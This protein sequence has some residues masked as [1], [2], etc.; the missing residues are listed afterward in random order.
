MERD[1]TKFALRALILLVV[2]LFALVIYSFVL[3]PVF[4]G[5]AISSQ[6]Q[7]MQYVVYTLLTQSAPPN[8]VPTEFNMG[9]LSGSFVAVECLQQEISLVG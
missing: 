3:K 4:S 2:I 1:N 7:G 5:Y 8:C 9:N 6:E